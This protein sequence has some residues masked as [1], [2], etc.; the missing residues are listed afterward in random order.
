MYPARLASD[1]LSLQ[2]RT[3]P[4]TQG[5]L[6]EPRVHG[7]RKPMVRWSAVSRPCY[8]FFS[9][10]VPKLAK[11]WG[12]VRQIFGSQEFGERNNIH[13]MKEA[14]TPEDPA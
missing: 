11:I 2:T 12:A 4:A 14:G 1:L 9:I 8:V 6:Y 10:F 3:L 7:L 5:M 13:W